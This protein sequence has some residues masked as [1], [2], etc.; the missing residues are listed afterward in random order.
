[1][2]IKSIVPMAY[3][4]M[5]KVSSNA[6]SSFY[7]RQEYLNTVKIDSIESGA[8][9]NEVETDEI[10]DAGLTCVVEL[11]A[12]EYLARAEQCKFGLCNKLRAKK[13]EKKYIDNALSYLESKNYLSDKRFATA[14]INTRRINHFE[15]RTKL[16]AEL[17]QR[18][19]SKDIAN[20]VL[21]EYFSQNDEEYI[22]K[23][24]YEKFYKHGKRDEKLLAAMVNAG[25]SY[26]M[27]KVIMNYEL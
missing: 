15:G 22:C 26:K 9:F 19:I 23:K 12:V 17:L 5:Y 27:V 20:E 8:E 25:F 16:M 3:E 18:G 24:A 7:V 4:G 14:W 11:K 1:M 13:F 6:C 21:D 10:L 2:I